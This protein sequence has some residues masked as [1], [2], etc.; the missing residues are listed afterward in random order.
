MRGEFVENSFGDLGAPSGKSKAGERN[1]GVTS[2]V[3]KPGI[4]SHHRVT[5][6]SLGNKL[7]G[8]QGEL[9]GEWIVDR[10]RCRNLLAP[11][12]L[13]LAKTPSIRRS[14]RLGRGDNCCLLALADLEGKN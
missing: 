9:P 5:V 1:H 8:C 4:A 7:I 6:L 10:N 14:L 2:P 13:C 11:G 12:D 3:G